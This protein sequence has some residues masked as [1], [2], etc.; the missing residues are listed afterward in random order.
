MVNVL[1]W[2]LSASKYV[3][4]FKDAHSVLRQF[5]APENLLKLMKNAFHFNSKALFVLKLVPDFF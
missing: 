1:D 3:S 2:L 5:L 4:G